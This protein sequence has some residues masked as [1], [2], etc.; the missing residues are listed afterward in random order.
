MSDGPQ[1][2]HGEGLLMLIRE[3]D[4]LIEQSTETGALPVLDAVG[5]S[6]LLKAL[7]RGDREHLQDEERV[8]RRLARLRDG[9]IYM[10]VPTVFWRQTKRDDE[11]ST[12]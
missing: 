4:D 3:I 2:Y 1:P 9:H 11:E 10:R 12:P 7:V 8:K 5:T 6:K